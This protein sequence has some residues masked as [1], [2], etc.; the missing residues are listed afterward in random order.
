MIA[1]LTRKA[2]LK[3]WNRKILTCYLKSEYYK[4]K[5]LIQFSNLPWTQKR[6]ICQIL[7]LN[8]SKKVNNLKIKQATKEQIKKNKYSSKVR[9]YFQIQIILPL[10]SKMI[11]T[12]WIITQLISHLKTWIKI[13]TH[14]IS[15][16]KKNNIKIISCTSKILTKQIQTRNRQ[17]ARQIH[18]KMIH[19]TIRQLNIQPL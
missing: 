19:Q 5:V 2:N 8:I 16:R 7:E 10:V 6:L 9:K 13:K 15:K 1:K 3:D 12:K 17:V 14:K 4:R 18:Q 11:V